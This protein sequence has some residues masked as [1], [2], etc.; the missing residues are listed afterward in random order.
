[1]AALERKSW[2]AL[3]ELGSIDVSDIIPVLEN[4]PELWHVDKRRQ[5][6]RAGKECPHKAS[7][8]CNAY[9]ALTF[10]LREGYGEH[11]I[12]VDSECCTVHS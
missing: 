11:L 8:H 3:E 10:A 1:M 12:S 6:G 5:K 2:G 9:C 4:H 7:V